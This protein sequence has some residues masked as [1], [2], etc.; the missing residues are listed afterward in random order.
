MK[1]L[2][3][4]GVL[5]NTWS[6]IAHGQGEDARFMKWVSEYKMQDADLSKVY[7]VWRSNVEFVDHQNSLGLSYTL[8]LNQFAHLVSF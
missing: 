2:F 7:S 5:L 4:L 1:G 3:V 6:S 8:S